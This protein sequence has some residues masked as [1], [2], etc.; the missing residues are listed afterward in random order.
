MQ[1]TRRSIGAML[2]GSAAATPARG[3]GPEPY[4]VTAWAAYAHGPYP[5]GNATAQPDLG[6]AF[7]DAAKGA[8]DQSF[9]LILRPDIWGRQARIRLTNVYGT[10]PVTFDQ[11]Y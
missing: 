2:F 6:F 7:P 3:A 11:V 5:V 10:T 1:P 4:F 8:S 9:R